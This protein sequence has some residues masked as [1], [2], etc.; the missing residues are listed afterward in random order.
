[1]HPDLERPLLSRSQPV[2]ID[3]NY[4]EQVPGF[5]EV[6][7]QIVSQPTGSR[8]LL[9]T[10]K[11]LSYTHSKYRQI[12]EDSIIKITY[13][14]KHVYVKKLNMAPYIFVIKVVDDG[15]VLREFQSDVVGN[16]ENIAHHR[17]DLLLPAQHVCMHLKQLATLDKST[18]YLSA[19]CFLKPFDHLMN[20]ETKRNAQNYVTYL[21]DRTEYISNTPV[22]LRPD[23]KKDITAMSM[24]NS[25]WIGQAQNSEM[26]DYVVRRYIASVMGS[27]YMYPGTLMN[28]MYNPVKRNW[29]TRAME[30]PGQVTL[31]APYLDSGGAGYVVTLSHTIFE[32]R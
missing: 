4:L 29:F 27:L 20:E 16:V 1:M 24:I 7:H 11:P 12:P 2:H 19:S 8:E 18:L 23:I 15:S 22:G 14:W 9:V 28:N 6:K 30:F 3:I 26:R 13:I 31:T 17:I 5:P 32:G 10:T 21:N 25:H